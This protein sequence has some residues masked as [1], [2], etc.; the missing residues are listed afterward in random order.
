VR[1]FLSYA[2]ADD[3][4][5]VSRLAD[6]LESAG[7]HVW[8]DRRSLPSRSL[9]FLDEIRRAIDG[10]DRL[11]A[12]MGPAAKQSE[13]VRS[14]WQYAL[15]RGKP[16]V[17]VLRLGEYDLP[18]ELRNLHCPDVR[19]SRPWKD[20]LAEIRRVLSDA[21]PELGDTVG[22]PSLPPHFRPRPTV[23]SLLAATVMLDQREPTTPERWQRVTLLSGMGGVGKSVLASA[24]ARFIETR[25]A[26][27]DG[28]YWL[29]MRRV[30]G[31][32]AALDTIAQ[33]IAAPPGGSA[34]A[35]AGPAGERL[36]AQLRGKRCLLVL[37]N[38]E[39]IEQ[40]ES[41]VRCL[42]T[43]GR[44]LVTTRKRDL[45]GEAHSVPL[46]G[47]QG[48]EARHQ[49]ADWLQLSP[50]ALD[51]DCEIILR[52]CEGN[53]FAIA[54]CGSL[55]ASGVPRLAVASKLQSM[56][57]AALERRFPDYE[58]S[59][60]LPCLE[61]SMEALERANV[62][63]VEC[64]EHMVVFPPGALIPQSTLTL[65]WH[66][67]FGLDDAA[68]GFELARLCSYSMVR[69]EEGQDVVSIHQ[70]LHAYLAQRVT[71]ARAI[72]EILLAAYAGVASPDWVHGPD[73]GYYYSHLVYHLLAARGIEAVC[74][75]LVGSPNWMREKLK[76]EGSS[77][78]Y[79]VDV[80]LALNALD[81]KGAPILPL[82]RLAAARHVARKGPRSFGEGIL[83]AMVRLGLVEN[84]L[85]YARSNVDPGTR[86]RQLGEIY[87]TLTEAA[88]SRPELLDEIERIF[89]QSSRSIPIELVILNLRAGRI[90][91]TLRLWRTMSH[92]ERESARWFHQ[93]V[94]T[95][96]A[97]LGRL[98]EARD[99]TDLPDT[100]VAGVSGGSIDP[101]AAERNALAIED[102]HEHDQA[103]SLVVNNFTQDDQLERA[104]AA[105]RA[106]KR[107]EMRIA[108]LAGIPW[109]PSLR[110]ALKQARQIGG[111]SRVSCLMQV[112][113]TMHLLEN[114]P[115]RVS[116]RDRLRSW[117]GRAS[118]TDSSETPAA[119][120]AEAEREAEKLE[121]F[122]RS[123]TFRHMASLPPSRASGDSRRLL[124]T[125]QR[126][127]AE[128][129]DPLRR[130]SELAEIASE[131]A[132]L[133]DEPE[134]RTEALALLEEATALAESWS[135]PG[136]TARA[137][138]AVAR[139]VA[140]N[141]H[142]DAAL[143]LAG[144]ITDESERQRAMVLIAAACAD[145]GEPERVGI[146]AE[147]C[148]AAREV[149]HQFAVAL[150]RAGRYDEALAAATLLHEEDT[151][152]RVVRII[153]E[154]G[155]VERAL[156]LLV[157]L[158]DDDR[159]AYGRVAVLAGIARSDQCVVNPRDTLAHARQIA[160]AIR[161]TIYRSKAFA[162]LARAEAHLGETSAAERFDQA[163]DLAN[164]EDERAFLTLLG[165]S[166]RFSVL[167]QIGELMTESGFGNK[168]LDIATSLE[169][170]T[171]DEWHALQ[172]SLLASVA[173][174]G[175]RTATMD[176]RR[177][178]QLF[179]EAL[180][181]AKRTR[182]PVIG[183]PWQLVA[184]VQ[185]ANKC[186]EAGR[187]R[188]A[189]D[190]LG[191]AHFTADP[192]VI[193]VAAWADSL[194]E[195]SA[196]LSLQVIAAVAEIFGWQRPDWKE[197]CARISAL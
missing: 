195:I 117:L 85:E 63:A 173:A 193:G 134:S 59:G 125:A 50:D 92:R 65:L 4:P 140:R 113:T 54:L 61:V 189:F 20:A 154:S 43:T 138:S 46:A 135:D 17:P 129:D 56:D 72:H 177:S 94:L 12:V 164:M 128:M 77:L 38:V 69:A 139:I 97:E 184:F 35:P 96:L 111:F 132:R 147:R 44:L 6:A 101:D 159:T 191:Q 176:E 102:V 8:F 42:D 131:L 88:D 29:D 78:P 166:A 25:R 155:Q 137:R 175:L 158:S 148:P 149:P 163:V 144:E 197:T 24:L 170:E 79:L 3:E 182:N 171:D 16:V 70:L 110:D 7:V 181:C 130:S 49:L 124:R 103:L 23:L 115:S 109:K 31:A 105:A 108:I 18:P 116:F 83:K 87:E 64:L 151:V 153:A 80:E 21:A 22:L 28:I 10:V 142:F 40:I 172:A 100:S 13:Y 15:V 95:R 5:F 36:T 2:R 123:L 33:L 93:L 41:I 62:Q 74:D 160:D 133:E 150:A 112:A 73:D 58:Y 84:A 30:P 157:S 194:E 66:K 174:H 99:L 141:E 146:I 37:D 179:S 186:A 19:V 107:D 178:V 196:G 145:A 51:E 86:A 119:L 71:D 89:L 185:I 34:D 190:A 90:D 169:N 118:A 57:L 27:T 143:S 192:F 14:E 11:I 47:L 168:A 183:P 127:A 98:E 114:N 161:S 156:Q 126:A 82:T 91:E 136:A 53:P 45:V 167:T 76:I 26:F 52:I 120:L 122:E 48:A 75:L 104:Y 32:E 180:A 1:V 152:I 39:H 60:L 55:I 165:P 68:C 81:E 188:A 121:P 67:S 187:L 162:E 9:T 106:I